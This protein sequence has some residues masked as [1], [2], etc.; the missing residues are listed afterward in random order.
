MINYPQ[1]TGS[2]YRRNSQPLLSG[3]CMLVL[4]SPT[5]EGWKAKWTLAVKKVIQIFN[6]RPGGGSNREP[7]DWKAEILSLC[8][9]LRRFSLRMNTLACKNYLKS[10]FKIRKISDSNQTLVVI[11][12]LDMPSFSTAE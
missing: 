9:P 12:V 3:P 6:P 1:R 4:I 10:L 5:P 11:T 7:Q 2:I 8:Q